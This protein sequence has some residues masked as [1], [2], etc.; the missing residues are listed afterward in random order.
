MK[1]LYIKSITKAKVFANVYKSHQILKQVCERVGQSKRE[2]DVFA[3][4]GGEEFVLMLREADSK[5]AYLMAE[6]MRKVVEE[7]PFD[8]DNRQVKVTISLGVVALDETNNAPNAPPNTPNTVDE[9]LLQ[10]D[11]QLY[12]AKREGRNRTCLEHATQSS[13]WRV[14]ALS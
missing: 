8:V 7:V 9:F 14:L 1:V 10:A 5:V 3:R 12:R 4:F 13:H 2:E 6:K 11:N